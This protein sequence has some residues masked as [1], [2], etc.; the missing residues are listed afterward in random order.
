MIEYLLKDI[1]LNREPIHHW[2][3]V[4]I[5]DDSVRVYYKL[6]DPICDDGVFDSGFWFYAVA[7]IGGYSGRVEWDPESTFVE[8]MYSGNAAFDGVRHL[9][10]GSNDTDNYGYHY[11]PDIDTNIATLKAITDL[12]KKYCREKNDHE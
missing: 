9:Y 2:P 10:M 3:Y 1:L 6:H 5:P 7:N 11:Y 4:S 12:E 8:C